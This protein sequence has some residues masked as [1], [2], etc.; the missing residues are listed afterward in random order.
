[1][2]LRP[3]FHVGCFSL[4]FLMGCTNSP[5]ESKSTTIPDETI[6]LKGVFQDDFLIGAAL[7][8]PQI[9]DTIPVVAALIRKE[10]N[11][12]T[13]ENVMK[14]MH[15]HPGR[16]SF[17]FSMPDKFVNLGTSNGMFVIG[18]TLVWHSQLA[19]WVKE[20]K[21]SIE[22]VAVLEDHIKTIVGKYRGRVHG[23]DVVNEALNENGTLRE[24]IFLKTVG[25]DYIKKA[26]AFAAA[27]D[28]A[29]ELYYNDYNLVNFAKRQGAIQLIKNIQDN[30]VK[31]DGVGIQAHWGLNKP[32][33]ETID[34]T[35]KAFAALGLK[36]M[37]TEL[38]IS[39]LPNPGDLQ[40]A[41]V[42]Q[43]FEANEL[44]NP[45][46]DA[47]PDSVQNQLANR[48]RDIF[49]VFLKHKDNISRVTFWGVDDGHSW[50]NNWPIRGR[51]NYP[52]LFDRNYQ[53]KKA[54]YS[55]TELKKVKD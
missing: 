50:K 12:I 4:L 21:D 6:S 43:N 19:P 33:I 17:N 22:M 5:S 35:I 16:D 48:Y 39:V 55:V 51:T 49:K 44:L 53:P 25:V 15:I 45:Y 10:F 42:N 41:D 26:F 2:T 7:N 14:W 23:W 27:E 40:G 13:A 24:S 52:L 18:H 3:I 37:F 30:N 8:G 32:S 20:I 11:T 47:L 29:A 31:I 36:I 28:P 46:P 54:Y 1:M 9:N 34:T 38:D